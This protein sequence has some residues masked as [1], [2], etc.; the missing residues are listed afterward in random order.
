MTNGKLLAL[1]RTSRR[2]HTFHIPGFLIHTLQFHVFIEELGIGAIFFGNLQT[3]SIGFRLF[4]VV[5]LYSNGQE[6]EFKLALTSLL[7]YL[8]SV[9]GSPMDATN[10]EL[11]VWFSW[12][13]GFSLSFPLSTR[14]TSRASSSLS[15]PVAI[16]VVSFALSPTPAATH[17]RPRARSSLSVPVAIIVVSSA[18]SSAPAA[19]HRRAGNLPVPRYSSISLPVSFCQSISLSEPRSLPPS[20]APS[21]LSPLPVSVSLSPS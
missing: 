9:D 8:I 20:V 3:R 6:L 12:G 5:R 14:A 15:V 13:H 18:L 10:R 21:P 1:Q 19:T 4:R 7:P 17:R 2:W 16:V 11:R